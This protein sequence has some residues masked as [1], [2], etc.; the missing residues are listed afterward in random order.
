VDPLRLLRTSGF[1]LA[2]SG[3]L[4]ALFFVLHPGGGDP[5]RAAVISS[6]PYAAEHTIGVLAMIAMLLGLIGYYAHLMPVSRYLALAGFLLAFVGGAGLVGV[7]YT[8]GYAFPVIAAT[9]PAL[10]DFTGPFVTGP[11]VATQAVPGLVWGA[12]LVLLGIA[13]LRENVLPRAAGGL[14]IIAAV[15]V[16]LPPEPVGPTPAFVLQGAAVL[17][18]ACLAWIGLV[19]WRPAAAPGP[20]TTPAAR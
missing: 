4:F 1:L 14:L 13:T 9:Q 16:D 10:L 15:V 20:A 7:I 11:F 3:V 18:G 12:G 8:D 5:T 2:A 17:M 19:I 6:S